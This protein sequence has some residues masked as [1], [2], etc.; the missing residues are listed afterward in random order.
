MQVHI[1]SNIIYRLC[2]LQLAKDNAVRPPLSAECQ[3]VNI[4][5]VFQG[6][7]VLVEKAS[8]SFPP[9]WTVSL[10]TKKSQDDG[11]QGTDDSDNAEAPTMPFIEPSLDKDVLYLF[12]CRTPR[13]KT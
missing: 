1:L 5:P 10:R 7:R 9:E 4:I 11:D 13:Q 8:G 3:K 2:R 6:S 12:L